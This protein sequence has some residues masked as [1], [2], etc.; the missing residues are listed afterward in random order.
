QA[1]L[2]GHRGPVNTAAFSRDGRE[3][4][5]ASD[6]RTARIWDAEVDAS[7][8]GPLAVPR[9]VGDHGLNVPVNAV[10]F[11]PDGRLALSAGDD[12]TARI[13]GPGHHVTLLKHDDFVRTAEFSTD[14]KLIITGSRD[15]TARVWRTADGAPVARLQQGEPVKSTVNAAR[16]SPDGRLALTAGSDSSAWLWSVRTASRLHRLEHGA[17]VNDARFSPN[18]RL[19]VTSSADGTAAIW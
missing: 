7:G 4:V 13:W 15:G 19:V 8:P 2:I 9:R 6:D 1:V 11:S 14:G 3:V 10:A 16:L 18:G 5:T 12:S 17:A